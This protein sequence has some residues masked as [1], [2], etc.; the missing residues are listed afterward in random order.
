MFRILRT[1]VLALTAWAALAAWAGAEPLEAEYT[2]VLGENDTRAD[3]RRVCVLEARRKLAEKAGVYV[4]AVTEVRDMQVTSD[5]VRAVAGAM[6]ESEVVEERFF[7]TGD[8]F[9]VYVKVR[10]RVD[11]AGVQRRLEALAEDPEGRAALGDS[12]RRIRELETRAG[13]SGAAG[14]LPPL[15]ELEA[16]KARLADRLRRLSRAADVV[17]S[18]GMS[19]AEVE[20][21][22]GEP[23]VKKLNDTGAATYLCANYGEVWVIYRDGL[24]A[25]RRSRLS[26][27]QSYGS[28]CHCAG[29]PPEVRFD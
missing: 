26:Y 6:V 29:M 5:E 28:D 24:V 19:R 1:A 17:V 15:E 12:A 25:C 3:A 20:A 2:Y 23:R 22:L 7:M 16:E 21:L 10:G 27:R 9:A 14:A 13:Q 4:E 11:P 18:R 8:A